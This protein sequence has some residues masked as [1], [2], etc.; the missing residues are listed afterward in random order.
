MTWLDAG[1]KVDTL[2]GHSFGQLTALCVAGSL[3]LE[4]SLRFVGGRARLMR[5]AWHDERGIMLSVECDRDCLDNAIEDCSRQG[6]RLD[7]ACYNGPRSFVV[8]GDNASISRLENIF[9][10]RKDMGKDS[11]STFPKIRM[12]RLESSHAFH[13]YLTAGILP[14]LKDLARSMHVKPPNMRIETCSEGETWSHFSTEVIAEHTRKPVYFHE[15]VKR[16]EKRFPGGAVWLEA[17]ASSPVIAMA[18]RILDST[19]RHSMISVDSLGG[20]EG[21]GNIASAACKLWMTGKGNHF[22]ISQIP[23][24][25]DHAARVKAILATPSYQFEKTEHWIPY[26]AARLVNEQESLVAKS[27]QVDE[28]CLVKLLEKSSDTALFAVDTACRMF[29]LTVRGHAVAGQSLCPAS[30]YIELAT[31]CATS[32]YL[33]AMADSREELLPHIQDL[34]MS[35]PLGINTQPDVLVRV[36]GIGLPGDALRFTI[37]SRSSGG[38]QTQHASGYISLH[39]REDTTAESRTRLLRRLARGPAR[40]KK[41]LSSPEGGICGNMV[42]RTFEEVVTYASYYHGVQTIAAQRNESAGRVKLPSPNH[43]ALTLHDQSIRDPIALD[44]FLQVAGIHVNCLS[45]RAGGQVFM[46]VGIDEV[47]FTSGF[48]GNAESFDE[49]AWIVHSHFEEVNDANKGPQVVTNN[50][51]VY[52]EASGN[53]MLCIIG[54]TFRSV[55]FKS[56]VRSL[57][58]LNAQTT[59]STTLK[60]ENTIEQPYED[61]GYQTRATA[62]PN[63]QAL[64]MD[65]MTP[66]SSDLDPVY[67]RDDQG[68]EL[69]SILNRLRATMAGIIEMPSHEI[70]PTSKLEV[71]GIDSLLVT[72]VITEIQKQFNISVDKNAF[73][74]LETVLDV[75]HYISRLTTGELTQAHSRRAPIQIKSNSTL[76]DDQSLKLRPQ[77]VTSVVGNETGRNHITPSA[78]RIRFDHSKAFSNINSACDRFVKETGFAN[79]YDRA[80]PLQSELVLRYVVEAFSTLDC[81]LGALSVGAQVPL[82]QHVATH[83]KLVTQLYKILVEGGLIRC[84]AEKPRFCRTAKPAPPTS[85]SELHDR[86]LSEFPQHTSETKLLATTAQNLAEC[87]SGTADPIA[88]LFGSPAAR[89]LLEDVYSNAPMFLA[90]TRVLAQYLCEVLASTTRAEPRSEVRILEIGAGTGGTTRYL[91]EALAAQSADVDVVYTFTDLSASLVA[92]AKR[93]FARFAGPRFRVEFS[94]LDLEAETLPSWVVGMADIIVSTNCVHATRD[95]ARSTANIRSMLRPDYEAMLCLVELMPRDLYWFDLVFG[96]LEGWWLFEDGRTY[97]LADERHWEKILRGAGFRW[98]DWTRGPSREAAVIRVISASLHQALTKHEEEA[99][100][101]AAELVRKE[102]MT[103]KKVGDL[104]L[105]ADIYYPSEVVDPGRKLPIGKTN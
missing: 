35:A 47:V 9:S 2:M 42:Y 12:S 97:A 24:S 94:V 32:I 1:L 75:S 37:F 70:L 18:N 25:R 88:L 83:D 85:S 15:A 98:V 102:T 66:E 26:K 16:I 38:N 55:L 45:E 31:R 103:Y 52:D 43:L 62:T 77:K 74:D 84:S 39:V 46:C 67:P 10:S 13:S 73:L 57:S 91:L 23:Q 54:A 71:L 36:G 89:A 81:D 48:V 6:A 68:P 90:K 14:A 30:M 56:V 87:L 69:L 78:S 96:L 8:A 21:T 17:G 76:I 20:V 11:R 3:S 100:G 105:H 49:R 59:E 72:E 28:P 22:W 40:A 60:K 79:F 34:E 4:D 44:N 104:D 86:L 61:S 33:E 58:R 29:Q 50:I 5:D 80:F 93:K 27:S 82:V 99:I 7:I 51:F 101:V 19:K 95:L 41:L 65:P 53:L 64:S 92:T 63:D